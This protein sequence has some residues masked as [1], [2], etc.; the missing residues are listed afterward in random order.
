M[1]RTLFLLFFTHLLTRLLYI[2]ISGIFNNYSLQSDS[3]LL[4]N[5]ADE[6]LNG[7]FNFD[8]GRFVASPLFSLICGLFKI[9][10]HSQWSLYLILFQVSFSA[11]SGLYIF[12]ISYMI[13]NDKKIALFSSL[14]FAFFPMTLWYVHTFSQ[15][16]VFQSL[17]IITIYYLL[18]SLQSSRTIDTVKAAVFFSLA[19]LTK[20]HILILSLFIPLIY[21]HYFRFSNTTIK[22]ILIFSLIAVF[23]SIPYGLYHYKT[24]GSY[25]ISSNGAGYQF[26]LGN[27]EAGYKTVVDVPKSNTED[28]K[29]MKDMTANAGYFN[30]SEDRYNSMMSHPQNIKQKEF[31]SGALDWIYTHPL[32][33]IQLK[34]YDA[35]FFILPGVSFRHYSF[36]DWISTFIICAPIYLLSYISIYLRCKNNF[37]KH[38]WIFY[39]FISMFIFSIV[40]YV[41]NRFRTITLE[42]FYIIYASVYL[43]RGLQKF[44][45]GREI[46]NFM[47]EL[48]LKYLQSIQVRKMIV[49]GW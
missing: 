45:L 2:N 43:Y 33:F 32:K 18:A 48:Y 47:D 23:F 41:Q 12:R 49:G 29:M 42:P 36:L 30:G 46:I 24:N 5:F 7:N 3:L 38:A 20:S 16:S 44:T 11:I 26:Y 19:Y 34:L 39:L 22:H 9:L 10:F 4:V 25:V 31:Y 28:Y 15:E 27:T 13:F 37:A 14:I 35:A 6:M 1:R 17:M 40:W 8:L 21:F